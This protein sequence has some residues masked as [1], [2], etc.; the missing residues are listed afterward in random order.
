MIQ[1]VYRLK[2]TDLE[3]RL[4]SRRRAKILPEKN[5]A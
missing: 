1:T 3:I 4:S 5:Q 2:A